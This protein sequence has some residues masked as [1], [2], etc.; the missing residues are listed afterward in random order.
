M[1]WVKFAAIVSLWAFFVGFIVLVHLWI[2]V[3]RMPDRWAIISRLI[4]SLTFLLRRILNIQVTVVGD[5]EQLEGA[6]A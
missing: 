1:R 3:L 5:A 6:V 2:S 4:C